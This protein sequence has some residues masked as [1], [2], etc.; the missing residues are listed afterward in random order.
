MTGNSDTARIVILP[1]TPAVSSRDR[2]RGA[3]DTPSAGID[4]HTFFDTPTKFISK[5]GEMRN[6]RVI[7]PEPRVARINNV[8]NVTNAKKATPI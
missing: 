2:V 8:I 1:E 7:D 4:K 5:A 3:Y 6:H